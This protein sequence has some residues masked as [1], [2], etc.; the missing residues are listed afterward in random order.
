MTIV[1]IIV[2]LGILLMGANLYIRRTPAGLVEF[3][4]GLVLKVLPDLG[5][6]E[7]IKYQRG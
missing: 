6:M 7:P 2:V 1:T 5:N 3:K 4:S